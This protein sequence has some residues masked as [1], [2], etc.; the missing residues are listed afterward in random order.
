MQIWFDNVES[1]YAP[2]YDDS[3][4]VLDKLAIPLYQSSDFVINGIK[5]HYINVLY[6]KNTSD[7]YTD[8]RYRFLTASKNGYFYDIQLTN[9]LN[10]ET[11]SANRLKCTYIL[12]NFVTI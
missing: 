11:V 8:L 4:E 9:N 7:I 1:V 10:G 3:G 12:D 5:W 6:K 2:K